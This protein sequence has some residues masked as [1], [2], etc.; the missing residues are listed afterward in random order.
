MCRSADARPRG[1]PGLRTFEAAAPQGR[2]TIITTS[3]L[4]KYESERFVKKPAPGCVG[5][6]PYAVADAHYREERDDADPHGRGG[7]PEAQRV[8]EQEEFGRH[9]SQGA[10]GRKSCVLKTSKVDS[11]TGG[12]CQRSNHRNANLSFGVEAPPLTNVAISGTMIS[13]ALV[14]EI[15][16][17]FHKFQS[18]GHR[19][20]PFWH[21]LRHVWATWHVM[22]G[23]A[24]AELQELGAWKSDLMVKRYAHFA[25]EQL[26]AAA[27][28]L[29]T[30]SSTVGES[31][32]QEST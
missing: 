18:R 17:A 28:R 12:N 16:R 32:T 14:F 30:F 1:A 4:P 23:T 6:K 7:G 3:E 13:A 19:E 10:L 24:I 5:Q 8:P 25:P 20:L 29:A 22:A 11:R 2:A 27:N 31:A 26:R 15:D 21:D 9:A